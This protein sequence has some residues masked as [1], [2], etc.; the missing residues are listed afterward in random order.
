MKKAVCITL[1]VCAVVAA[2][3][4]ITLMPQKDFS[5][6]YEGFDLTTQTSSAVRVNTYSDYLRS[7]PTLNE[8]SKAVPV[9]VCAFDSSSTGVHVQD[10]YY[11]SRVLV[12][13]DGSFVTWQVD[14]PEEGFYNLELDYIAVPSRNVNMERIVY[15]NGAVPFSGADILTFKR[16]W[17][18]GAAIREDNQGN[19]IR[20]TQ[21]EIFD[22]QTV[23]FKSDSG[24]E[25]EPYRFYFN[26]GL[27]SISFEATNEPMAIRG[28]ALKP[29]EKLDSYDEYLAKQPA[30]PM[31]YALPESPVHLKVQGEDSVRRSDPSLFARY[32]R[33]SPVTEPYDIKHT[34]FN[35]TGGD[36]WKSSGQWI[37][38]DMEVPYTGWYT[39]SVQARQL[40]QRG[41]VACRSFYIDGKIPFDGVKAV[42]FGY[43]SDWNLVTLSDENKT[44]YKFY[45]EKG[46]HTLRMEVTLGLIGPVINQLEDSVFRLNSIYRTILVL[47]GRQPDAFRDYEIEKAYPEE[48]EAMNIEA[49]RLYKMVDDFAKVTGQKSDKIAPAQTLAVQL[50]EFYKNPYK[51]TKSF[52]NF[53]DNITSMGSAILSL[54]ES[55]L[56]IDFIQLDEVANDGGKNVPAAPKANFANKIKHETVSFFTS[57]FVDATMLGDVYE[58]DA[59]H[60]I[61][62]WIVTARD[63]ST[64]LKNMVDDSFSPET[65]IKVNVKLI[66]LDALLPAVTAG[67]GPDVVLSIDRSKPVDYALRH[68]NVNLKQFPDYDEVLKQF[69]HSAYLAYEYDNGL[70]ALPETLTFNLLFYRKDIMEQLGAEIPQTWDDLIALLPT[71]Q[72]RNNLNVAMPY[73][74]IQMPD[75]SAFYAMVYQ[76]GG[77]IYNSKGTRT[78]IDSEPGVKAFK[79]Y[80]SFF[81]SYGLPQIYDFVSRF[82]SGDMPIG[83]ANYNNYN[84]LTVAAPEI[85]GLWDFTYLPG[86]LKV[87]E[88]GNEYIDR[89]TTTDGV[90]CMMID[91]SKPDDNEKAAAQ[92]EMRRKD[93]WEFMKWWV[94]TETQV[95]F[96]REMEAL[97][98]ASA[99]YQTA[100]IEALKQLPWNS[101]QIKVLLKTIEESRGYPEV[102]GSY[103][104]S[105]YVVNAIRKVCND[106]DDPREAIIDYSRKINDELTR[107]RQ[108]FNL[109]TEE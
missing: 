61:E 89:A 72:G 11:G 100:N 14:V 63:Q 55:K 75:N 16:I 104:T 54:T 103:S 69:T 39:I 36:S 85:R 38:W 65:G 68:A 23:L 22:W 79:T 94:S 28:L 37:E 15:L 74:N 53:K 48:V 10:D 87:D 102:P 51:I 47:T 97:L 59:D 58:K 30:I 66:N 93:S 62:V 12:T 88:N 101:A 99:R 26:K 43:S 64:V 1:V 41:Y 73:P 106:K 20:P 52:Q 78:L 8:P 76:N 24:Y 96:G 92:E 86:T 46:S 98:G 91:K 32:D 33:S 34:R 2:F 70:Y 5:E 49:K 45:L 19:Q 84:T 95:R 13:D 71:L 25:V 67:N 82:R 109:P 9:D 31:T 6:K 18:D 50:E 90:C 27:N 44:P 42:E 7:Q 108:E 81:N 80:T 4:L 56:D 40:Y 17:H 107:K 60:L 35:Y 105:R 29:V 3:A 83:I 57:F 21:A 77:D